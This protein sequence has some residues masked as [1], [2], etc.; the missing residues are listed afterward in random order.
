MLEQSEMQGLVGSGRIEHGESSFYW[1]LVKEDFVLGKK[2]SEDKTHSVWRGTVDQME[3]T[4]W[5]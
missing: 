4:V 2:H 3:M 1:H 5:C